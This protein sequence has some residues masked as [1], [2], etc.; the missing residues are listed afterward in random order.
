MWVGFDHSDE[1]GSLSILSYRFVKYKNISDRLEQI[2][3][4]FYLIDSKPRCL[5]GAARG[6]GR[7]LSILS[8]RFLGVRLHRLVALEE[9]ATFNSI[10]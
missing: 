2:D 5:R 3:F 9:R 7:I 6:A 8:Y 10:L 1:Y 4:Q